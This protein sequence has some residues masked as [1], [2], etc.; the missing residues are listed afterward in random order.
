MKKIL[1]IFIVLLLFNVASVSAASCDGDDLNSLTEIA[2]NVVI[3]YKQIQPYTVKNQET[4]QEYVIHD[5]YE[6]TISNFIE[7]IY[8]TI[9][10]YSYHNTAGLADENNIYRYETNGGKITYHIYSTEC[11]ALLR[12]VGLYLPKYNYYS[13]YESCD[14]LNKIAL[15]E[16]KTKWV[17]EEDYKYFSELSYDDFL[18]I[19][20]D[21]NDKS[22]L[23]K[24][25]N[26][27]ANNIVFVVSLGII[28][29]LILFLLIRFFINKRRYR[30]E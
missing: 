25:V 5:R 9:G 14:G 26:I 11:N 28:L 1:T 15:K 21:Y 12:D 8:I 6:V 24:I 17:S 30:L 22:F 4:G 23:D 20:D 16:C 19:I 29:L 3:T 2:N 13:Y 7:G 10:D 27:V 18:K